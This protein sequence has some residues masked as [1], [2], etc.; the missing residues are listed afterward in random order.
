MRTV[1]NLIAS[2]LDS[3]ASTND[4]CVTLGTTLTFGTNLFIGI[5]PDTT[6]DFV[7]IIPYGG[8]PPHRDKYR[9][10][11]RFQ[12]TLDTSS[13]QKSMTVQQSIINELHMN[14]INGSALVTALQ[15][16]PILL[17]VYEGGERITS[18]SNYEAKHVKVV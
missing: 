17:D 2:Y 8:S 1:C 9:Q 12:I 6:S 11:P 16:T 10:N 18:V 14:N 5:P 7:C 4:I 15:S 13:R 3:L